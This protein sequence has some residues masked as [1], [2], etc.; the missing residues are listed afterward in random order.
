M[1]ARR[2]RQKGIRDRL[3]AETIEEL[4]E[5]VTEVKERS[6]AKGLKMN[7]KKTKTM[8]IRRNIDEDCKI[9]ISVDGKILEQVKQ[10]LYLGHIITEDG[11]CETEIRRRLEIARTNFMNMKNLLTAR[12]L[13]LETRKKLIRCYILSTLL[14]ASETWA[15]NQ[16]MMEKSEAFKFGYGEGD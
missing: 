2:Q 7:V 15:I 11:R 13:R 5:L 9:D 12:V 3:I 6:L 8:V 4:Q 10:Y 14:Y 1:V 16:I